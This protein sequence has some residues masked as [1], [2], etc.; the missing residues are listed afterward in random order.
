VKLETA[1][2]LGWLLLLWQAD[3]DLLGT[4][5]L[6][7]LDNASLLAAGLLLLADGSVRHVVLKLNLGILIRGDLEL[8]DGELLGLVA[9]A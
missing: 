2:L 8:L 6:G 7:V 3:L 1:L 5:T 4:T 9:E